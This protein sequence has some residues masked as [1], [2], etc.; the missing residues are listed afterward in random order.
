MRCSELVQVFEGNVLL[1][2][3][4]S[5]AAAGVPCVRPPLQPHR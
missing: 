3:H 4:Q 1:Y 2:L 5:V